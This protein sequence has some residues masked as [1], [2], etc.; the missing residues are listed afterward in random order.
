MGLPFTCMHP[1]DYFT[2]SRDYFTRSRDFS[3][4]LVIISRDLV[5]ICLDLRE[6]A[7]KPHKNTAVI[8]LSTRIDT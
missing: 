8:H 6:H 1:R 2:R 3:R 5:I 4:D 7:S